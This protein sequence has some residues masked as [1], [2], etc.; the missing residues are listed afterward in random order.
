MD[1]TFAKQVPESR[2]LLIAWASAILLV[3]ISAAFDWTEGGALDGRWVVQAAFCASVP[4]IMMDRLM[5]LSSPRAFEILGNRFRL[6][7]FSTYFS[8]FACGMILLQWP[9]SVD[10]IATHITVFFIVAAAMGAFM[11]GQYHPTDPDL[12]DQYFDIE[13]LVSGNSTDRNG[14]TWWTL[15][16]VIA[17][18]ASAWLFG[19]SEISGLLLMYWVLIFLASMNPV[20]AKRPFQFNKIKLTIWVGRLISIFALIWGVF[21]YL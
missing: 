10:E 9:A 6:Y 12:A 19:S 21:V 17:I 11:S 13:R 15:F 5:L 2:V 16:G 1:R 8:L 18:L 3:T 7:A 4:L 20:P 14:Y